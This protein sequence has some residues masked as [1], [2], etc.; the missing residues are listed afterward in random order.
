MRGTKS[1]S[2][3][4]AVAT[5]WLRSSATE[6]RSSWRE[7]AA[8][9]MTFGTALDLFEYRADQHQEELGARVSSIR[10]GQNA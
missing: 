4:P 1:A 9:W 5:L 2:R 10:T 7:S 8:I 6:G 3:F